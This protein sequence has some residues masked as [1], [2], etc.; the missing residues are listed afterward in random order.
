[1]ST[2]GPGQTE[3]NGL[4]AHAPGQSQYMANYQAS[5]PFNLGGPLNTNS[6]GYPVI[7]THQGPLSN[8]NTTSMAVPPLV[9][10]SEPALPGCAYALCTADY[11][12]GR[13]PGFN[14]PTLPFPTTNLAPMQQV[15]WAKVN[16]MY[17]QVLSPSNLLAYL[18][19]PPQGRLLSRPMCTHSRAVNLPS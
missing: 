14:I 15:H 19:V 17:T 4:N 16:G 12:H 10:H 7:P 5:P 3:Q 11:H 2:R 6:I 8:P 18:S 9:L 1:M 13:N